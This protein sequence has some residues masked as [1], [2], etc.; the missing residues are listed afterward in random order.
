M[1][2]LYNSCLL[3]CLLCPENL[4]WVL[5]S[6]KLHCCERGD[7]LFF[8]E[9]CPVDIQRASCRSKS[10]RVAICSIK[11]LCPSHPHSST[12]CVAVLLSP[13]FQ[14]WHRKMMTPI[15]ISPTRL[16]SAHFIFSKWLTTG[17]LE[18]WAVAKWIVVR[19]S[20]ASFVISRCYPC[21]DNALTLWFYSTD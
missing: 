18:V 15:F 5:W 14:L 11:Q 2:C 10:S 4:N 20:E 12:I 13:C 21:A 1:S 7:T 16:W 17:W 19:D 9:Q 6:F 8:Q 3:V